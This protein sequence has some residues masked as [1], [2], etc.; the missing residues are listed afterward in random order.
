MPI[1][2][3]FSCVVFVTFLCGVLGHVVFDCIDSLSLPSYLLKWVKVYCLL[4]SGKTIFHSGTLNIAMEGVF[5]VCL[6]VCV[7]VGWGG[8]GGGQHINAIWF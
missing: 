6:T 4:V 8:G 3:L 5:V 1:F 2:V 7:C